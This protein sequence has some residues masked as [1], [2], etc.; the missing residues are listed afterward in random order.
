VRERFRPISQN[1]CND[2]D[3]C[4]ISRSVDIHSRSR[5]NRC[6]VDLSKRMERVGECENLVNRDLT[7]RIVE[8]AGP[9]IILPSRMQNHGSRA[10]ETSSTTEP[11]AETAKQTAPLGALDDFAV[12]LLPAPLASVPGVH[13]R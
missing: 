12:V 5:A 10:G 6:N 9:T 3:V 1:A 7:A 2:N 13:L 4:V 8:I 11:A